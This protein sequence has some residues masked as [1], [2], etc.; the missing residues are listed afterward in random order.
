MAG[1]ILVLQRDA[2]SVAAGMAWLQRAESAGD[3]DAAFLLGKLG[4]RGE[5]GLKPDYVTAREHLLRAA[6]LGHDGAGYYLGLIYKNGYGVTADAAEAVRWFARAA[7]GNPIAR[8]MLA[9]AYRYGDGVARD[10]DRARE[11]YESAAEDDSPEAVQTLAMAY[12]DG[13]LGI[14]RDEMQH[15]HYVL[16]TAHVLKHPA[17]AP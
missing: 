1:E 6:G 8:F 9:N 5:S 10:M 13:E 7:D 12:R 11:L 3:A 4:F 14:T 16:E 15:R 17:S 2:T